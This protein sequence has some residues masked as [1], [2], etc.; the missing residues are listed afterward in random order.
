[1]L[2]FVARN[3]WLIVV[4]GV[5]A[6]VFGLL[7]WLWP[8]VTLGA[9]VLLWGAYAFLD[10]VLAFAAAFSGSSGKPWW[11]L[12][13]EGVV[14]LGAAVAT[15]VAP[16]ITAVVLLY[17][18]AAWAIVHGALE[19]AAAIQLRKEIQGEFWLGLTG[20]ASIVFGILLIA[21]PGVGA[22]AVVWL[23]GLYSVAFGVLLVALGFRVKALKDLPSSA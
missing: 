19:I 3:W 4:R 22:V 5:C 11:A 13:L 23:I 14:S 12:V 7:A 16:G 18:I 20:L 21:R 2:N 15:L 1:M 9:L 8:G 10:G 6:M 17:V